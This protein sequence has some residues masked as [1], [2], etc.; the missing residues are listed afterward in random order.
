MGNGIIK[1]ERTF[2]LRF[3]SLPPLIY[4]PHQCRFHIGLEIADNNLRAA[5]PSVTRGGAGGPPL[6]ARRRLS[7]HCPS[8][9]SSLPRR[10]LSPRGGG[11]CH[12]AIARVPLRDEGV[13]LHPC[14]GVK[15]QARGVTHTTEQH[16]RE[17]VI[18]REGER[19]AGREGRREGGRGGKKSQSIKHT[20]S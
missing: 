11:P 10:L 19:E 1:R 6:R 2:Y 13:V 12:Q 7:P 4:L 14:G 5:V 16:A 18:V 3:R 20:S 17:R 15:G 9:A 8:F